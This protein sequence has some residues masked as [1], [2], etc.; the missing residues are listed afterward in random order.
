MAGLSDTYK[1]GLQNVGSYQVS[2]RPWLKSNSIADEEVQV[3]AFPNVTKEIHVCND[4][5]AQSH[6]LNVAFP[7]PRMGANLLDLGNNNFAT[8]FSAL[9]TLTVSAWFKY[10]TLGNLR[11]LDLT[12]PSDNSLVRVQNVG[13]RLKLSVN[14]DFAVPPAFQ[15]GNIMTANTWHHIVVTVDKPGAIASL[16][17]DGAL[18]GSV[19][20]AISSDVEKI[21]LG[22]NSGT[23]FDGSYSD[24]F[25]FNDVLDATESAALFNG[26]GHIDPRDHSKSS[27]LVSW[28][29]F[30]NNFYKNYF[31]TPDTGL[32]AYDRISTNNLILGQGGAGSLTPAT[33]ELGPQT[34]RAFATG[35]AFQLIGAQ[36]V[37]ISAKCIFMAVQSVGGTLEYS[38]FSSLTG[39][40]AER[41]KG[42]G[43]YE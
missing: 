28:W 33:F 31:S 11:L 40:P 16:Y 6:T 8:T 18:Q 23:N 2:G 26:V 17:F 43:T 38:I 42:I 22:H 20:V 41:M 1:V 39:I 25:L 9:G 14:G 12:D 3:H 32:I 10:E 36:Q 35:Q 34:S 5:N 15:T 21:S 13:A 29:A 30:E 4:H 7:E 24:I 37:D 19:S 27:N